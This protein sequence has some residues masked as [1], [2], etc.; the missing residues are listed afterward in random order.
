M[1]DWWQVFF[2]ADYVRLWGQGDVA[3]SVDA[4]VSGLWSLLG[5]HE[6]S[7]VLDAPCGYGRLSRPLAERGA[8]VLGVDQSRA[9]LDHAERGRGDIPTARLRYVLHD[10]RR[11]LGE[12]GFDCALNIFTSLGYGSE[13]ED[14]A[15][16]ATLRTAVR[17]GGLVFVETAHRDLAATFLAQGAQPSRRLPDG[18]LVIEDLVI[19][20]GATA[21]VDNTVSVHYVGML[22]N[23]TVFDSSYD[24]GTPLPPFRLGAGQV[25]AGFEQGIVGMRVGGKRRLTIPPSLG[26]GNQAVGQIPPNSTLV[27]EVEL[28]EII[29]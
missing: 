16:L 27:F 23:G 29:S 14:V 21:A 8:I 1:T 17:P 9:L 19:G 11:P 10:L 26:Y 6:G 5:L 15:I 24:R 25:I 20:T 18:T 4:Q 3:G 7:R 13:E 28:L 2:D 22:T 12:G